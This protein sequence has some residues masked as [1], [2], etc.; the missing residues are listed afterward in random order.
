MSTQKRNYN[1]MLLASTA[2]IL[3]A[4][5]GGSGGGNGGG[6]GE[7]RISPAPVVNSTTPVLVVQ[8]PKTPSAPSVLKNNPRLLSLVYL[9][10]TSDD[11]KDDAAG[12]QKDLSLST[13]RNLYKTEYFAERLK[14][15]KEKVAR[16]EN[17]ELY[18]N[19]EFVLP[20]GKIQKGYSSIINPD[21]S[22]GNTVGFNNLTLAN[23]MKDGPVFITTPAAL[24]NQAPE[25]PHI[26]GNT[27]LTGFLQQGGY[28]SFEQNKSSSIGMWGMLP[29]RNNP[30]YDRRAYSYDPTKVGTT[31]VDIYQLGKT[32]VEI[33]GIKQ[34][35]PELL[36]KQPMPSLRIGGTST[37]KSR[38]VSL[39]ALP[40]ENLDIAKIN[41]ESLTNA[42]F[43]ALGISEQDGLGLSWE[44]FPHLVELSNAEEVKK[45]LKDGVETPP[46]VQSI[47]KS[48]GGIFA[49]GDRITAGEITLQDNTFI[50]T[51]GTED[52]TRA[53]LTKVTLKD[54]SCGFVL[55]TGK[56]VKVKTLDADSKTVNLKVKLSANTEIAPLVIEAISNANAWSVSL[57]DYIT[58]AAGGFEKKLFADGFDVAKSVPL[59]A[60]KEASL[61]NAKMDGAQKQF[62]GKSYKFSLDNKNKLLSL[63]VEESAALQLFSASQFIA[64]DPQFQGKNTDAVVE[65]AQAFNP[66]AQFTKGISQ[67]TLLASQHQLN[68][69]RIGGDAQAESNGYSGTVF[70]KENAYVSFSAP[71]KN[72]GLSSQAALKYTLGSLQ[73]MPYISGQYLKDDTRNAENKGSRTSIGTMLLD[74]TQVLGATLTSSIG[75][76]VAQYSSAFTAKAPFEGRMIT[77]TAENVTYNTAEISGGVHVESKGLGVSTF[78]SLIGTYQPQKQKLVSMNYGAKSYDTPLSLGGA[79]YAFSTGALINQSTKVGFSYAS[80]GDASLSFNVEL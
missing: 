15:S 65:F 42:E 17:P 78:L 45:G 41:I 33:D 28:A 30:F 66:S 27:E 69:L 46:K 47:A 26:Q 38:F 8:D 1:K 31:N 36:G 53:S 12:L 11:Y 60:H 39:H 25:F 55:E 19:A 48:D 72:N 80:N 73:V 3:T 9:G 77:A 51:V 32:E 44:Y 24:S 5:G 2:L 14:A 75:A 74:R 20:S 7:D 23:L 22:L 61:A 76:S 59:V 37:V 58:N 54:D 43:D 18:K 4:C 50:Q 34:N 67:H 79:T 40:G 70:A 68:L 56:T 64:T 6:N 10:E 21:V 49:F 62:S 13:L 71:T 35:V 16:G 29:N 63:K 52:A 57:D